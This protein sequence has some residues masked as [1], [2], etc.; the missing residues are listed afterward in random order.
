MKFT[1]NKRQ[2]SSSA[3]PLASL[4]ALFLALAPALAMPLAAQSPFL[5]L[6]P[7]NR[8]AKVLTQVGDG[9]LFRA[10][11]TAL[12]STGDEVVVHLEVQ[13][14]IGVG[15]GANVGGRNALDALIRRTEKEYEVV[16]SHTQAQTLGFEAF[17]GLEVNA[18][19][20]QSKVVI[21]A[22]PS[23][24]E[25][26]LGLQYFAMLRKLQAPLLYALKKTKEAALAAARLAVEGA[27]GAVDA[28]KKAE[29]LTY[30]GY[31]AARSTML[32][33]KHVVD[34]V[35]SSLKKTKKHVRH[36]RRKLKRFGRF[37]KRLKRLLRAAKRFEQ[38]LQRTYDGLY[39]T[40]HQAYV[41]FRAAE[42]RMLQARAKARAAIQTERWKR[43]AVAGA[44]KGLEDV[45]AAIEE[46]TGALM[47]C[48]TRI[49]GVEFELRGGAELEAAVSPLGGVSMANLGMGAKA[50]TCM[51]GRIRYEFSPIR[52]QITTFRN[53]DLEAWAGAGIGARAE[54]HNVL[55]VS[56]VFRKPRGGRFG[57]DGQQSGVST[58]LD[59]GIHAVAGVGL[60]TEYGVARSVEIAVPMDVWVDLCRRTPRL[61]Q[62]P[63]VKTLADLLRPFYGEVVIQDRWVGA[64][65]C[66]GGWSVAG[67]GFSFDGSI[68]WNDR[69]KP[70]TEA[71]S[72]GEAI[73]AVT[74]AQWIRDSI[75]FLDRNL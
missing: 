72:L 43:A 63:S 13:A 61:A 48:S 4:G 27:M 14:S 26:C 73:Q 62:D 18:V 52:L 11:R 46:V 50:A 21:F 60:T 74:R 24:D 35:G 17:E 41:V 29:A 57:L 34:T 3:S 58:S 59:L 1:A 45:T 42:R 33:S 7:E 38:G 36:V 75:T 32:E 37:S 70:W 12:N 69:G 30:E 23:L 54:A 15:A 71:I 16:I 19:G 9:K 53:V 6:L 47:H 51:G 5:A 2:P 40:Y 44:E 28:A 20:S 31:K 39:R 22:F 49:V 8:T 66:A 10:L 25:T 65:R 56:A 68:T 64:V 55:A 67:T